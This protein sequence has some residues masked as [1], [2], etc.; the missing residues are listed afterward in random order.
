MPM[1]HR[2]SPPITAPRTRMPAPAASAD[3]DALKMNRV[4]DFRMNADSASSVD[5]NA[6]TIACP[7]G[8]SSIAAKLHASA[9]LS[10][11]WPIGRRT[12]SI[13]PSTHAASQNAKCASQGPAHD[14]PIATIATRSV[15]TTIARADG[16]AV[17]RVMVLIVRARRGRDASPPRLG[18]AAIEGEVRQARHA[19]GVREI[20]LRADRLPAPAR[21]V[22][23]LDLEVERLAA[24]RRLVAKLDRNAE[25]IQRSG[26]DV[27]A[28]RR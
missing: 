10:V 26:L 21:R 14:E 5:A 27:E 24:C 28:H 6:H 7:I 22:P 11:A 16:D 4:A 1:C 12:H 25:L 17:P 13:S 9:V 19:R 2:P 8:S 23:P 3:C 18:P 15:T 20:R